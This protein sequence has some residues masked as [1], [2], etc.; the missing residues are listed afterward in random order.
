MTHHLQTQVRVD[1][2]TGQ[3]VLGGMGKLHMEVVR[4][5]VKQVLRNTYTNTH[6]H[7]HTCKHTQEYNIDADLGPLQIAYQETIKTQKTVT[8]QVFY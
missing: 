8:H 1:S 7:I 5:R 6:I 3:T 2:T 4:D